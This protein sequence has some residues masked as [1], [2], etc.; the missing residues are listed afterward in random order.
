MRISE[1]LNDSLLTK[2]LMNKF[3]NFILLII[4][5]F[6]K[7]L[8]PIFLLGS[9]GTQKEGKCLAMS[10]LRLSKSENLL[11]TTQLKGSVCTSYKTQFFPKTPPSFSLGFLTDTISFLSL[12]SVFS[13]FLQLSTFSLKFFES[14][15]LN[16]SIFSIS[17]FFI[18]CP[19]CCGWSC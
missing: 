6:S 10:F 17:S 2:L 5:S 18:S 12:N 9:G 15:A 14:S 8:L 13:S 1:H 3:K 19:S 4:K 11:Q 7:R 16:F